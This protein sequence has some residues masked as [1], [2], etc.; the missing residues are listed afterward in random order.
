MSY[1]LSSYNGNAWSKPMPVINSNNTNFR[2]EA[3]RIN[4]SLTEYL[5]SLTV[6]TAV[7]IWG[8][9]LTLE[10]LSKTLATKLTKPYTLQYKE[11]VTSEGEV[12]NWYLLVVN[13][14]I[15]QL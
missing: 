3:I 2:N 12:F 14:S 5:N 1:S 9:E 15:V 4:C 11:K 13:S 7:N 6:L 8:C 10:E